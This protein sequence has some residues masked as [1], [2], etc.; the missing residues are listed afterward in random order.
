V[1]GKNLV[2]EYRWAEGRYE[3]LPGLATELVRLPVDV[4]V[5]TG[6]PVI[7]AAKRATSTIP[8]VS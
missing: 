8:I 1:E 5:A 4:I 6:D 3:R 2:I 7:F